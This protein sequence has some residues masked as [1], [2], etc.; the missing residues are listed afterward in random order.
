[1]NYEIIF[2]LR[3][4]ESERARSETIEE[5]KKFL[6]GLKGEFTNL[7]DLGK[8]PLT[9]QIAKEIEGYYYSLKFSAEES[10]L[11]SIHSKLKLVS[12]ILRYILTRDNSSNEHPLAAS[13]RFRDRSDSK[14]SRSSEVSLKEQDKVK[15][16]KETVA[17]KEE[18]PVLTGE[19]NTTKSK[20]RSK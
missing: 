20:V 5:L 15:V 6:S 9:H 13:L 16:V 18:T 12:K 2:V 19:K 8:K 14:N 17:K 3:G 7:E 1:M 10:S 11:P 4:S